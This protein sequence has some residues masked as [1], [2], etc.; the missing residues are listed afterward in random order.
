MKNN[1][2][3]PLPQKMKQLRES[4]K[5]TK[6]DAASKLN[7]TL[8]TYAN[9]EYGLREPDSVHLKKIADLYEVS[10]DYLL[11][12]T[13]NPNTV[14]RNEEEKGFLEAIENLELKRWILDLPKSPEEDLEK[15]RLMW[16][17][18]KDEK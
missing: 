17:I 8:S 9:W 15:L 12:R 13:D 16:K 6:T 10:I 2:E 1:K 3:L 5:W 14:E 7:K 11:G 18:I 4:R